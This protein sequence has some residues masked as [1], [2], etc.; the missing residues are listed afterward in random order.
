MPDLTI[1]MPCLNEEANISQSIDEAKNYLQSRKLTGEVLIVDNN[2]TDPSSEIAATHGAQVISELQRGYG[3]ALRTG[4]SFFYGR[5]TTT[6]R[7]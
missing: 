6:W 4:L 5:R 2:S 1:L 7:K 3:R